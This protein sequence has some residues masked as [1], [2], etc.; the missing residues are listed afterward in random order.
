[1]R[2]SILKRRRYS[3]LVSKRSEVLKYAAIQKAFSCLFHMMFWYGA[4][5]YLYTNTF[6]ILYNEIMDTANFSK[7]YVQ[8][9]CY[10]MFKILNIYFPIFQTIDYENVY[11]EG[12]VW[13]MTWTTLNGIT[14]LKIYPKFEKNRPTIYTMSHGDHDFHHIIYY[15]F[16][17]E[18]L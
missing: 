15:I 3:F 11:N 6:Y 16:Y 9:E 12:R 14:R 18:T 1:M 10:S 2:R 4:V 7:V 5:T 17:K 8:I 13:T